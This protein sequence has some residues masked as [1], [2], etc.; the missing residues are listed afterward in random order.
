MQIH[1]PGYRRDGENMGQVLRFLGMSVG[2]VQ[3][4]QKEDQR[5]VFIYTYIFVYT[6]THS[7][8][9]TLPF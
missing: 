5:K 8:I 4:F 2:V 3:A 6:Y 9:P 1:V 7:Y